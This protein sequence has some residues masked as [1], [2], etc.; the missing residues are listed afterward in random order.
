M[1]TPLLADEPPLELEL[2]PR[3]R[4]SA[5]LEGILVSKKESLYQHETDIDES[6]GRINCDCSGLIGHVLRH[7]FP[8]AYLAVRGN[9]APWKTRPLAVTFYQTFQRA[10]LRG[11]GLWRKIPRLMDARPGDLMA[12]RKPEIIRGKSTGY[13]VMVAG[14]PVVDTDGRIHVRVVDS[15]TKPHANDN[16]LDGQTG[17]GA[18]EMWFEVEKGGLPIAYTSRKNSERVD[19]RP[20]LIGRLEYNEAI[21]AT[22]NPID[23]DLIG[24]NEAAAAA[25]ARERGFKWRLIMRNGK[26]IKVSRTQPVQGRLNAVIVKGK[27]VRLR[28]G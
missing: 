20:I 19:T 2:N 8:E 10:G 14:I 11:D 7:D 13:I 16:R 18:G 4:L 23:Q 12:W 21:I 25:L 6:A 26:P 3:E 17:I 24:L 15:T 22:S 28:R 5:R 9:L 1:V 27:V